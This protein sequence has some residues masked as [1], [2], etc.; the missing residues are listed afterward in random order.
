M[1]ACFTFVLSSLTLVSAKIEQIH[2]SY[3]GVPGELAVDFVASAGGGAAAYTSV[4]KIAWKSVAATQFHAPTIGYMS[5]A[6]LDYKGIQAGSPAYYYVTG[7]SEN[8]SIFEVTPVVAR[9]E[10]FAVYGD[11]GLANDICMDD[12]IAEAAKGSFDSVLH[13]GDWLVLTVP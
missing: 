12:L 2:L 3:T 11:F 7:G 5:Q 1:L 9:P 10:V 4:D 8:S 13:V 6:L